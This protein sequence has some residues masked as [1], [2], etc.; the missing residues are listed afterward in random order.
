MD[1]QVKKMLDLYE[2]FENEKKN[3]LMKM[4]ESDLF[5]LISEA[6]QKA[7]FYFSDEDFEKYKPGIALWSGETYEQ[8]QRGWYDSLEEIM[9]EIYELIQ[10]DKA[11]FRENHGGY[12]DLDEYLDSIDI[13]DRFAGISGPEEQTEEVKRIVDYAIQYE[14]PGNIKRFFNN[15]C[16]YLGDKD[17]FIGDLT[18]F[19][20]RFNL[21]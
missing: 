4:S 5:D 17:W 19:N 9:K 1:T 11:D 3:E 10:N 13:E 2:Q 12:F 18:N 7:G 8:I 21:F 6:Y 15:I 16:E 20:Q 14:I